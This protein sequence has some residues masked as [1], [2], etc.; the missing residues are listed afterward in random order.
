MIFLVISL[1]P[2][3]RALSETCAHFTERSQPFFRTITFDTNTRFSS[4]GRL[5][6]SPPNNTLSLLRRRI[7]IIPSYVFDHTDQAYK[8]TPLFLS[9]FFSFHLLAK[10]NRD[11]TISAREIEGLI[12]KGS[13]IVIFEDFVLRL[14]SWLSR[15]PGGSLA[16]EHMIGRDAT[17]EISV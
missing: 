12:A 5:S 8:H 11:R 15:H 16:I 14:D 6:P 4:C 9:N 2:T 1:L 10:M 3:K 17:D 13:T 7:S